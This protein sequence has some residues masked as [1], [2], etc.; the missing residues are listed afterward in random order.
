MSISIKKKKIMSSVW[1]KQEE[2]DLKFIHF[3]DIVEYYEATDEAL[4]AMHKAR[5]I[6]KMKVNINYFNLYSL[7]T[8]DDEEKK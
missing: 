3:L 1:I 6:D 5:M 7:K 4:F 2:S 8:I